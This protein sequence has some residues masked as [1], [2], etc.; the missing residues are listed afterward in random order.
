[1]AR[2]EAPCGKSC[3]CAEVD[4]FPLECFFVPDD[5]RAEMARLAAWREG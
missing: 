2:K 3:V 1:M 5:V 4:S